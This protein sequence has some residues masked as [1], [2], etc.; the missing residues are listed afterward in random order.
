VWEN[1][2]IKQM[3]GEYRVGTN[4]TRQEFTRFRELNGLQFSGGN[5]AQKKYEDVM[6]TTANND[7]S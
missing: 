5:G 1:D 6:N 4:M 3:G 2:E 7:A